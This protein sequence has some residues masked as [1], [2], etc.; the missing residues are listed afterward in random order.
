M[1]GA[2]TSV[3][4]TRDL[5]MVLLRCLLACAAMRNMAVLIRGG[6]G[7]NAVRH[8]VEVRKFVA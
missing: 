1:V 7:H 6:V 3:I 8:A 2:M 5:A 4:A